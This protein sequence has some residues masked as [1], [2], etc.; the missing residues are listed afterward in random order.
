[1]RIVVT[2]GAGYIGSVVAEELVADGHA[3]TVLD[4]LSKG[5][6]AA[7]PEGAAFE[8]ADVG[9]AAAVERI[10]RAREV[11]AVVHMAASSL[12]GESVT[13]PGKYY[14]N[15]VVAGMALLQ[16]MVKAGTLRLVFSSTAATYGEPA[17]QPIEETDPTEPTNPYGESKLA[18]ERALRWFEGAHGL[19]YASLRYFNAAGASEHSGEHHDPETHLIP[20]VLQAAAGT[21]PAVTV[22]GEDYPTLDGTCVRDYVHVIDLARAHVAALTILS[23]RSAIYN[24]GCGGDGYSV[25]Q[26]IEVARQVT[27]K[28]IPVR[29]GPRRAGDPAVLVAS[30]QRI[31]RDLGWSPRFQDL[32]AIVGSAWQWMQRHPD[33]YGT[34]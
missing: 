9:D 19:R 7:V 20:L 12:V 31:R 13:D 6:R 21:R 28:D 32:R 2:G 4:D 5:H 29:V 26:V 18:F 8:H 34:R 30:S 27:G 24:L 22:F 15:N 17:K 3:V 23:E 25:R 11:E 14:R 33:G 16:A 10:L 1:M